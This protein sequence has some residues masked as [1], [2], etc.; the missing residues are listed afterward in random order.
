MSGLGDELDETV[1]VPGGVIDIYRNKLTREYN[2]RWLARAV[3]AQSM[4]KEEA[5]KEAFRRGT[6]EFNAKDYLD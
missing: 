4:D 1:R 3:A 2:A 5:L 6:E